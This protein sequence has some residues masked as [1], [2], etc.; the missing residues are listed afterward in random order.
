[1]VLPSTVILLRFIV[2]V[3]ALKNTHTF[4]KHH[5]ISLGEWHNKK[6]III[7]TINP[8]ILNKADFGIVK[9]TKMCNNLRVMKESFY[10]K[11]NI[12]IKLK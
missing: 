12:S 2:Y 10:F 3:S 11:D 8:A 1:M 9:R 5:K 6:K 7:P 4:I